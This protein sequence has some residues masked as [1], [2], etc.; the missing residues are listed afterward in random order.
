MFFNRQYQ[1]GLWLAVLLGSCIIGIIAFSISPDEVIAAPSNDNFANAQ[2]IILPFNGTNNQI[3]TG[4]VEANE[5]VHG[6]TG[7]VGL[8]TVWYSFSLAQ[9]GVA[10]I[11]TDGSNFVIDADSV[12]SVYSGSTLDT[13]SELGC[14]DDISSQDHYS[15]LNVFL[16][17]GTYYIKISNGSDLPLEPGSFLQLSVTFT[18]GGTP[19]PTPIPTDTPTITLTPSITSTPTASVLPPTLTA[20]SPASEPVEL[21]T[22]G[23]FEFD[24]DADKVPDNWTPKMLAHDKRIC[25]KPDKIVAYKGN[26]AFQFK[27]SLD[28]HSEIQQLISSPD[29][30]LMGDLVSISL[31]VN[32][33]IATSASVGLVK[34]QY[35]ESDAGQHHDGKDKIKLKVLASTGGYLI[36]SQSLTASG[37]TSVMLVRLRFKGQTGKV[38]LDVAS[39]TRIRP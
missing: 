6:C 17:P 23:D 25:N 5:P 14:S 27:G 34:L 15:H 12:L 19:S 13:L 38:R 22:N 36:V 7:T 4:T 31:A 28:K 18:A 26:C 32:A 16:D 29:L 33:K 9:S 20:T 3:N 37:S 30:P 24:L 10:H 2:A 11:T 35:L 21:L 8:N 1:P 39:V